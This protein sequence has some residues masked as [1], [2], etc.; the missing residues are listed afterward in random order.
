MVSKSFENNYNA[1]YGS[2]NKKQLA[3]S[4]WR[5]T[6]DAGSA[7]VNVLGATGIAG[8]KFNVPETETVKFESEITDHFTDTNSAIQDHIALKPVTITCT[9]FVGDYFYSVNQIEDFLALI[10]PTLT[11]VT[12][13]IPQIRAITQKEKVDTSSLASV[14]QKQDNGNY[15]INSGIGEE[16]YKYT[17]NGMDL[18]TLFQGLYKLKSA[19]AR[20]FF[21]FEALRNSRATFSVET[22]WKRYDNMVVLSLQPKRDRNADITE[23]S[24]TFKQ[25]EFTESKVESLAEYKNRIELQKAQVANKGVEKGEE[26]SMVTDIQYA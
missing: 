26:I 3:Q 2:I 4:M 6:V 7:V 25:M 21:F 11:L 20:A 10:T 1:K 9:G 8:F 16:R 17:F 18:F 14:V 19:Q 13:F 22:S 12:E 15:M 5:K 24:V 23:F